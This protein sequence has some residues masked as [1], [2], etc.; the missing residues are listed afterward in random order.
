M[1]DDEDPDLE[2][3]AAASEICPEDE[4]AG[5]DQCFSKSEMAMRTPKK[6]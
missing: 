1:S 6:I 4:E 5:S 2:P 3:S